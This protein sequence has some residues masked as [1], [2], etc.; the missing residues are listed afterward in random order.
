M[1]TASRESKRP[2]QPDITSYFAL[3][4]RDAPERSRASAS[5]RSLSPILPSNVQSS[6]LN[7]G[8]RVRKSVPEGYRTKPLHDAGAVHHRHHSQ[9]FQS[10]QRAPA[11]LSPYCGI[12][13]VG[14]HSHQEST[15]ALSQTTFPDEWSDDFGLPGSSQE[16]NTSV[17][18]TESVPAT[19]PESMAQHNKRRFDDDHD[20]AD[21]FIYEDDA[22]SLASYPVS[23]TSM[24]DFDV[25]RPLAR[26]RTRRKQTRSSMHKD[27]LYHGQENYTESGTSNMEDFGEADFLRPPSRLDYEVEMRGV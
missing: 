7:V 23:H 18:S 27:H 20:P 24:P 16:S 21:S 25:I 14:G 10:P 22:T 17:F 26:P 19:A 1:P 8:M 5:T 15:S 3:A 9:M 2:Y 13:K 11:E 6:L 12:M 4:D